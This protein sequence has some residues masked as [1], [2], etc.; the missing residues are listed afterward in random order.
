MNNNFKIYI[1][2]Y[3][4][5]K[6]RK[7]NMED[8]LRESE[9]SYYFE[10]KFDRRNLNEEDKK[11]FYGDLKDSYK[12]NF[13]SHI[14]CYKLLSE[15]SNNFA[16][17]LEDDSP[18]DRSFY[19]NIDKYL[20]KLPSDFGMFFISAGKNN[21][22]IPIYLRKPFKR[23]YKKEDKPSTWGGAGASRN[24]DAYFISKKYAKILYDEF[25]HNDFTTDTTIDWWMNDVIRKYDIPVYWAEPVL[26]E[27]NKFESSF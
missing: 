18:P 17:I 27:T 25:N 5:L 12:A 24:A 22:H 16:L 19:E 8:S 11:K 14:N 26:I 3:Q 10:K 6:E 23:I 1:V 9:F 20:R 13:L 4:A 21:F 2:H 15:S 7:K